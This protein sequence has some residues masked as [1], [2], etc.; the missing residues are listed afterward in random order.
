MPKIAADAHSTRDEAIALA[1]DWFQAL[2]LR[3]DHE[4]WRVM[5]TYRRKYGKWKVDLQGGDRIA[6]LTVNTVTGQLVRMVCK[7]PSRR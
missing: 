3:R 5:A 1:W 6:E 7:H 2:P 4:L